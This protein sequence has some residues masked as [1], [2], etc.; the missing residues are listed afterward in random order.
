MPALLQEA[1]ED[2]VEDDD[3]KLPRSA[4][5]QEKHEKREAK[6]L[7]RDLLRT[8]KTSEDVNSQIRELKRW[9]RDQTDGIVRKIQTY[10]T[11]L[12]QKIALVPPSPGP[13]GP[14]GLPGL[15]GKNGMD[16]TPGSPGP[17]GPMGD[18]GQSGPAGPAGPAGAPGR[19][20]A[21]GPSGPPGST[22]TVNY[23]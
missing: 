2:N 21:F 14:P 7:E 23:V 19:P 15:P 17:P 20:G 9:I 4:R 12:S 3:Q 10:N 8:K 11:K 16:G 6:R 13:Q 1:A 22:L 18:P 5:K